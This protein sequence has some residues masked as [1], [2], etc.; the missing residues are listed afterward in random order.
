MTND[1][2]AA[3]STAPGEAGISVVR[4]SGPLAL[5]IAD[6]TFRSSGSAPSSRA[7]N[8]FLHGFI[9]HASFGMTDLDV[10]EVI[11]LIYRA[12]HSYTREDVVEIQGHGGSTASRRILRT[13]LEAGARMA[14]PGEFTRRAFLSGRIDLLQAEAVMDLIRAKSERAATAALEQL[15]GRLSDCITEVYDRLLLI[16]ADI[17]ATLDFVENELPAAALCEIEDR[18]AFVR[19]SMT[20]LLQG[21][22]EGHLLREGAVVVISGSPNVGKS[23]LMNRL[24]GTNRAIVTDVPGTTRDTL[25]EQIVLAGIPIRL[26]DTAGLRNSDC[27]I[28]K[29]GMRRAHLS[30][31]KA[32]VNL[33]VFDAS[34][35]LSVDEISAL[36]TY[37]IATSIIVLNKTDLGSKLTEADFLGFRVL[38]CSLIDGGTE[39][40]QQA[41]LSQL[42]I[43]PAPP[44]HAVISERH[45]LLVQ[46]SLNEL[47]EALAVLRAGRDEEVALAAASLRAALESLGELT[48]RTYTN[49]LLDNIFS[50]FCVGK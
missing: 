40:I 29:E 9:H 25:E 28:E 14:E 42:G 48:G 7:A 26:V 4:V 18:L 2:I 31:R 43:A 50:R 41:I 37:D 35:R 38:P 13:I 46:T 8:T 47:E 34:T 11:L 44:P 36:E 12:P 3:V 19:E 24:L 15:D 33:C 32:D 21:W 20:S 30:I 5:E 10:D 45:R 23:T 17:E 16:A 49:D 6:R 22:E 39:A 27:H 1:T